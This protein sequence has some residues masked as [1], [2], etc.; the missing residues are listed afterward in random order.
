M[1]NETKQTTTKKVLVIL[2]LALALMIPL[3][4]VQSQISQ[5]RAYESI[6]QSEVAKGWG[7]YVVFGS[8][9][10]SAP[11]IVLHPAASETTLA[12]DSKEKKRGIFRVPVY[13]V[14]LRTRVTFNKPV[15]DKKPLPA[16]EYLTLPVNQTGPIQSF[17]IKDLASGKELK[18]R[19]LTDGI[20]ISSEELPNKDFFAT[21][22]EIEVT[23]RGTKTLTYESSSER[24]V[25]KMTG[26]W[27][28]PKF[29]E[30]ALPSE[31][32]V[33]PKGFEASWT[34]NALPRA[35]DG[36][37]NARSVG[38]E[39]LWIGTDYSMIEKSV[40]YGILFIALTFLLVL[41]VEFMSKARIHPLQYGLIGLSI[42]L[43]YLLLLALSES[44]GF[45]VAYVLASA[46]VIALIVFY[47]KGFLNQN[48]FVRMILIEQVTLSGFFY[49]LL[50]LEESAL[51]IGSLGLFGALATFMGVT[52]RF[53]WYTGSFKARNE[54]QT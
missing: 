23:T 36:S 14:T 35:E 8:P 49:V 33:S 18:G 54:S 26:N 37:G 43:F 1:E 17:R 21:P 5:R 19:L 30:D 7:N 28:K 50:S 4:L 39:H 24:D 29:V 40:K 44:T 48:R 12:V 32:T 53:D 47:V 22:L 34:L 15:M 31:S 2:A 20:R 25:V 52:R 6:A 51:L 9:V 38:M 3:G 45:T 42:S 41:L 46:A 10:L 11:K 27:T 13:V 16:I